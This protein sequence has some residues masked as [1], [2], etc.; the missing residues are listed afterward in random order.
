MNQQ[1]DPAAVYAETVAEIERQYAEDYATIDGAYSRATQYA[2]LV[3]T[4]LMNGAAGRRVE[5]LQRAQDRYQAAVQA[6]PSPGAGIAAPAPS[7][8]ENHHK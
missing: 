1:S 6:D 5:A 7:Q 8:Q 4:E 2:G 3:R